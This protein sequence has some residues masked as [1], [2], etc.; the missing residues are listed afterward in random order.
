MA[1][2]CPQCGGRG[3][4]RITRSLELPADSRSDEIAM[5][6]AMC[7]ERECGFRALA[8]YE[9]SR[10]GALEGEHWEHVGYRVPE[11]VLARVEALIA[12]CPEP[13]NAGCDCAAHRALGRTSST[14]R[15]ML[16]EG[17]EAGETFPILK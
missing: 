16:P 3:T 15:W 7:S 12:A 4:L 11:D 5:Q 14:G 17:V 2:I 13:S 8:V 9:E 1:F 6:V 10:R